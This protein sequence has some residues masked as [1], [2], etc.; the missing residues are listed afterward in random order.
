MNHIRLQPTHRR[1]LA[2]C[3]AVLA[4]VGQ[5][6]MPTVALAAEGS[7]SAPVVI[8][9]A[10]GART[11]A[12][13]SAPEPPRKSDFGGL[14]CADCVFASAAALA[15]PV[16]TPLAPIKVVSVR[17]HASPPTPRLAARGPPR[18]PARAPPANL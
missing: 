14:K 7:D 13:L 10:E 4:M 17:L 16:V 6:L 15:A 2:L 5:A 9:T 18:P 12:G 11:V 8:C 1:L 3:L